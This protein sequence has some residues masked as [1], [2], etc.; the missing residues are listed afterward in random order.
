M[1]KLKKMRL[2][3]LTRFAPKGRVLA[4]AQ[5]MPCE[6]EARAVWRCLFKFE[7]RK[8]INATKECESLSTALSE[9]MHQANMNPSKHK[10]SVPYHIQRIAKVK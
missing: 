2:R 4:G 10:S 5:G 8:D 9:C 7:G 6:Q 1:G 3:E